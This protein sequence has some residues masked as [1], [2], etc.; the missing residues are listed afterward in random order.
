MDPT[1]YFITFLCVA[2]GCYTG[3]HLGRKRGIERFLAFL[4]AHKNGF[5][6]EVTFKLKDGDEEIL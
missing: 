2:G 5:T 1:Y 3:F 6:N 4:D